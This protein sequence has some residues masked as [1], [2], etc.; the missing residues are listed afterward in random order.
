MNDIPKATDKPKKFW[1]IHG[2]L[3]TDPLHFTFAHTGMP[4]SNKA[5]KFHQTA[6]NDIN[7][8]IFSE[9]F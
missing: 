1:N 2:A 8:I 9:N 5:S 7:Y 4:E 6:I 3:G